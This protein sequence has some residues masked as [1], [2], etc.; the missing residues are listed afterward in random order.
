MNIFYIA[1]VI[2]AL[3]TIIIALYKVTI[4]VKKFI[5]YIE[6][7]KKEREHIADELKTIKLY[8]LKLVILDDKLS[9]QERLCAGDEYVANGGNGFVKGVYK[10]LQREVEQSVK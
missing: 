7:D 5:N 4:L 9:L 6:N 10:K 8:V 2:T 3:T 1:S